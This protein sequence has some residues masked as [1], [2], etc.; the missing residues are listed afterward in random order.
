MDLEFGERRIVKAVLTDNAIGRSD[1]AI[2]Q[3]DLPVGGHV[4]YHQGVSVQ[5]LEERLVLG[6]E[7]ALRQVYEEFGPMVLG[8]CR[9]LVGADAEDV[10]Q[11]VFVDAWKA[12]ERFDPNRG[13]LGAW[14]SG[15]S[16]FKSID[17]LRAK[18]RRPSIPSDKVGEQANDEAKVDELIDR[19]VL[20]NALDILPPIRREVIE[21]GFFIGLSHPEISSKLDLPLGT[22]KSH[23]RRGLE[24]LQKELRGS[25]V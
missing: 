6:D 15:I 23:M 21:L 24:A 8:L 10:A 1:S 7:Q 5:S 19:M 11:Q 22:V 14:L 9:K 25:H 17:F 4:R 12:R 18:R 20:K 3:P 2:F 16:R 13:S